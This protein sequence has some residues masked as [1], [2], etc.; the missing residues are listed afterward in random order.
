MTMKTLQ[1][2]PVGV[3]ANKPRVG[4]RYLATIGI[5]A[6]LLINGAG[7]ATANSGATPLPLPSY[8]EAVASPD[9]VLT[10]MGLAYAACVHEVPDGA[11]ISVADGTIKVGGVRVATVQKCPYSGLVSAPDSVAAVRTGSDA[12]SVV[13]A[14][15]PNDWWL[16]SWWDSS[17][18]IT[19]LSAQWAV[20]ANPAVNGATIFLFPSLE[21]SSAGG[22]IVQPVLQWG[23]SGAT[24]G[25]FWGV[26]NWFVKGG[27]SYHGSLTPTPAGHVIKGTISRSA[28][29]TGSWIVGFTDLT[30]GV[31]SDYSTSTGITSWKAVQ[32]GVLE[33][34]NATSCTQL[35]NTTGVTFSNIVV[36]NAA[37]SVTPSFATHNHA[38]TCSSSITP[39]AAT[40][41]LKWKAA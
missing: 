12:K 24:G 40:A 38:Q 39:T 4:L 20:P 15:F 35:P 16:D 10:P 14:A 34:Y 28:S 5:A 1:F 2:D 11:E 31:S 18:E 6:A 30:T 29:N 41:A 17:T 22:G 3:M 9:W 26:A 7:M 36:K 27:T 33:V 21:P 37:G 19:S 13:P 23:T 32:G 8:E 25:N